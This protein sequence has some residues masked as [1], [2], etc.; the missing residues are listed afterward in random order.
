MGFPRFRWKVLE[1]E[2]VPLIV[3]CGA[4]Q[5]KSGRKA[6]REHQHPHGNTHYPG[7]PF[8][9]E[10]PWAKRVHDGQEAV[11]TDAREE[12]HA[13]VHVGVEERDGDLAESPSEGPVLVDEVEHPQWQC[14]DKQQ[15]WHHQ[16]HHVRGG[17]VSQFQRARE[18]IKGHDICDESDH[19]HN[20]EHCAVQG[21]FEHI[22]LAAV[23]IIQRAGGVIHYETKQLSGSEKENSEQSKTMMHSQA[24][25]GNSSS[26]WDIAN[27]IN[28]PLLVYLLLGVDEPW[29]ICPR[30]ERERDPGRGFFPSPCS[31]SLH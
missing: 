4:V 22:I 7:I 1:A 27:L 20:A 23:W 24:I 14:E 8:G 21:V 2:S 15:V 18:D 10:R 28:F 13:A 29:K 30:G 11:H 3:S 16:V 12:E 17:L 19:K 25:S 26:G 9:P 6:P 31:G 5:Q